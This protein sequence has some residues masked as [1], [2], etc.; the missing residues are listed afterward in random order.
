MI[1]Y[2]HYELTFHPIA[3]PPFTSDYP[4]I[5][6]RLVVAQLMQRQL[7][8]PDVRGSNPDIGKIYNEN[9][10]IVNCNEKAKIKKKRPGLDHFF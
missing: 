3:I 5:I 6:R 8:I 4:G 7:P 2:K 10:C 1:V 9:L